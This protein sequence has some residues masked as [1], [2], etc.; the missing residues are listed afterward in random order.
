ILKG[1]HPPDLRNLA[2]DREITTK[3]QSAAYVHRVRCRSKDALRVRL[4]ADWPDAD[5]AI[6]ASVHRHLAAQRLI[7]VDLQVCASEPT[8]H[9]RL[10]LPRTHADLACMAA[11]AML[12][13]PHDRTRCNRAEITAIVL[14]EYSPQPAVL[15]DLVDSHAF[16]LGSDYY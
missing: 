12:P 1:L 13:A 8:Y 2:R 6:V 9:V 3:F 7:Q 15:V 5:R 4:A 14:P 16:I 10:Y 11:R